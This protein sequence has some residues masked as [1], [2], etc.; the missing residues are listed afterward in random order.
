MTAADDHNDDVALA[1]EY[2]LHLLDAGER[3]VFEVRL[4]QEPALRMIVAE[5]EADFVVLS[6]DITPVTPP[7]QVKAKIDTVLFADSKKPRAGW[8]IWRL[9]AGAGAA[10]VL[11]L[12]VLVVV[13]SGDETVAF[14]PRLAADIAA[15]DQSLVVRA[16]YSP[17]AG[18]L[19]INRLAGTARPGRVLELW[20]IAEGAA[21]PVSLGIL[22]DEASIDIA[23]PDALVDQID[24]GTLAISDEP[25]G[26]S[27]T[28][29]PTGEVL[30]AGAVISI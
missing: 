3:S 12:A 23:L 30:A 18:V 17:D 5:W 27:T 15:E 19:R 16:S 24:G 9:M 11:G 20:L 10:V 13:P 25:L 2:A 21:A 6:D 29:V 1:G 22:P 4:K 28:G 14:T 26:G 7:A 8:S